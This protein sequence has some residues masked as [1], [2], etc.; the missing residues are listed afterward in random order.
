MII[1]F[2][3]HSLKG[4]SSRNMIGSTALL[5]THQMTLPNHGVQFSRFYEARR[6]QSILCAFPGDIVGLPVTPIP[7][8]HHNDH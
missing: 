1:T 6:V 8:V 5:G 7:D 4:P 3:A 2:V